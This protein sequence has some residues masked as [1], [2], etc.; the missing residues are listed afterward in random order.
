MLGV[1]HGG[2]Y[3]WSARGP[4]RRSVQNARLTGLIRQSFLASDRTYGS[5]REHRDLV[6]WGESCGKHRTTR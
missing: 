2:F 4:S 3:G 1:S 5:P 6:D